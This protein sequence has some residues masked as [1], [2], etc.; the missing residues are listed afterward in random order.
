MSEIDISIERTFEADDFGAAWALLSDTRACLAH[1]PKLETLTHLGGDSWRWELEPTGTA[2]FS[3]AVCYA[4]TYHYDREAGTI[5]WEPIPEEGN[6]RVN[7]AF[8]L[9][10]VGNRVRVTL[11]IDSCLDVPAPLLLKSLIGKFARTELIEQ[12]EGFVANLAA[13]TNARPA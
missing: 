8:H 1:Y 5:S 3:H 6:A 2:G 7:G 4:V 9:T 10:E 12:V 13:A 11:V